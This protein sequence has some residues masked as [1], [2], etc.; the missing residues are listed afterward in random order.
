MEFSRQQRHSDNGWIAVQDHE[1]EIHDPGDNGQPAR[2]WADDSLTL[3]IDDEL[4]ST[5][6][7]VDSRTSLRIQ[8]PFRTPPVYDC[9][10]RIL[11]HRCALEIKLNEQTPGQEF[12]LCDQPPAEVVCLTASSQPL[13]LSHFSDDILQDILE[14]LESRGIHKGVQP[15]QILRACQ[16][17]GNWVQVVETPQPIHPE[18][19][20]LLSFVLPQPQAGQVF[21]WQYPQLKA[22]QAGEIIA[23]RVLNRHARPGYTIYGELLETRPPT[24]VVLKA[25]DPSVEIS[26][27]GWQALACQSGL[28]IAEADGLRISS[29]IP[30]L[31]V[32]AETRF[33]QL[34]GSLQLAAGVE[35]GQHIQ[36]TGYLEVRQDVSHAQLQSQQSLLVHGNVIRSNLSAGGE[37]AAVLALQPKL[38]SLFADLQQLQTIFENLLAQHGQTPGWQ[39]TQVLSRLLKTQF[40]RLQADLQQLLEHSQQLWLQPRR[41]L[42]LKVLLSPLLDPERPLSARLLRESC[43]KMQQLIADLQLIPDST[44]DLYVNYAQGADLYA[45][46]AIFVLGQGCYNSRLTAGRH[47]TICGEPGYCREGELRASQQIVAHE[48]G[49]PNGS[50]LKIALGAEGVLEAGVIYPGVDLQIGEHKLHLL[51]KHCNVRVRADQQGLLF[52]SR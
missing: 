29:L 4:V 52:G 46:G 2:L 44:A 32:P 43:Q 12:A 19:H 14:E 26:S 38:N 21:D 22:V 49:S 5:E 50:R 24:P 18:E 40:P 36:A 27:E 16:Q 3:F 25:L 20:L 45:S 23:Q 13:P 31:K 17:P 8:L 41:Q 47:I 10:F 6:T 7:P 37:Y 39:E 51:E 42:Q 48:L 11:P 15:Q 28:P 34:D 33:H 1:L 35:K 30:W 9:E